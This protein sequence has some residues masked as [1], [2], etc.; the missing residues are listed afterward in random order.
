MPF[1]YVVPLNV[2]RF[3]R[4]W[5]FSLFEQNDLEVVDFRYHGAMFPK[6]SEITLTTSVRRTGS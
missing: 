5:V 3:N 1:D 2:V 6:Q 4:A